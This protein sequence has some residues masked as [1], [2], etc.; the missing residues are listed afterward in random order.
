MAK[1]TDAD[2]PAIPGNVSALQQA[3]LSSSVLSGMQLSTSLPSVLSATGS[4]LSVARSLLVISALELVVLVLAAMLAVARLLASQ[5]EGETA[6][7]N[8]RGATRWQLARLT[9]AEVIPLCTVAAV[10]AP[11]AACGSLPC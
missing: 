10:A 11:W 6:L 7:L 8:A 9:G 4:N 2:M 3:L 1:F 5:R